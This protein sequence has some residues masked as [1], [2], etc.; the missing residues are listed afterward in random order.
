MGPHWPQTMSS[1]AN[2][3]NNKKVKAAFMAKQEKE[4]AACGLVQR[5]KR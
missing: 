1:I 4:L 2:H 5:I 3:N